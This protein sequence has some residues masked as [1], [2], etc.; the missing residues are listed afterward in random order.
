M[1]DKIGKV[2]RSHQERLW[3]LLEFCPVGE[4][5]SLKNFKLEI[6]GEIKIDYISKHTRKITLLE[7]KSGDDLDDLKAGKDF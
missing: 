5:K 6:H 7:E 2:D 3:S 1:I 4:R